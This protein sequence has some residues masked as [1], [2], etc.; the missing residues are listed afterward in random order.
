MASND[1]NS[2]TQGPEGRH[3]IVGLH[4]G[5]RR[6]RSFSD[7]RYAN[8]F[9]A[10]GTTPLTGDGL[11]AA[12]ATHRLFFEDGDRAAEWQKSLPELGWKDEDGRR[13]E[14]RRRH[15]VARHPKPRL[16]AV[17]RDSRRGRRGGVA[18]VRVR[19]VQQ[20]CI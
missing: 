3:C 15:P 12:R 6:L 19:G 18:P 20:D 4:R 7:M 9:A 11:F 5:A 16:G 13:L 10:D 8:C 17:A 1:V 2:S 14:D